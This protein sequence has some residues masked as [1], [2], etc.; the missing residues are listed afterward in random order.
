MSAGFTAHT[1]DVLQAVKTGA[2][3]VV[4]WFAVVCSEELINLLACT[5]KTVSNKIYVISFVKDISLLTLNTDWHNKKRCLFPFIVTFKSKFLHV[6]HTLSCKTKMIHVSDKAIECGHIS[7][8][9]RV[10]MSHSHL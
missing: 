4:D 7:C 1:H 5:A 6:Y 10:K 2:P 3:R 9:V 8:C